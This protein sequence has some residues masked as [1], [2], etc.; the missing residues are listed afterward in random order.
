MTDL[1]TILG[2]IG[3]VLVLFAYFMLQTKKMKSETVLYSA[4]NFFGSGLI[5]L[6]LFYKWN[7]SAVIIEVAWMVLS[8]YG[9]YKAIQFKMRF[10]DQQNPPKPFAN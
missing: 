3:V 2:L 5:L 4:L 1:P 7:L 9:I 10:S 8:A 6:S